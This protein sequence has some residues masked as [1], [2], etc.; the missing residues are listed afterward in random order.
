MPAHVGWEQAVVDK[1]F[2]DR[3]ALWAPP[4]A[5]AW[6]SCAHRIRVGSSQ[7]CVILILP[8]MP[9]HFF[10]PLHWPL[11]PKTFDLPLMLRQFS[12]LLTNNNTFFFQLLCEIF[13]H[14]TMALNVLY[15]VVKIVQC[16]LLLNLLIM[17]CIYT[18]S[19]AGCPFLGK[20]KVGKLAILVTRLLSG[21]IIHFSALFRL[22]HWCEF[23]YLFISCQ[24]KW[25]YPHGTETCFFFVAWRHNPFLNN[26]CAAK[27]QVGI[28]SQRKVNRQHNIC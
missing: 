10:L 6:C 27:F 2:Q 18:C 8:L 13:F 24:E 20:C 19:F 22:K 16:I 15:F 5:S 23:C 3:W 17:Y 21:G 14:W 9:G 28:N 26:Y 7:E 4:H 11:A 1:I 25:L 12:V